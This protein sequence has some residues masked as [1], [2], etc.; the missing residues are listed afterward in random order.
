MVR[1]RKTA[2]C[3]FHEALGR[4]RATA[5]PLPGPSAGPQEGDQAPLPLAAERFLNRN[6]SREPTGREA[7]PCDTPALFATTGGLC[8]ASRPLSDG[9]SS[10]GRESR[11]HSSRHAG[12]AAGADTAH[13]YTQWAFAEGKPPVLSLSK[14]WFPFRG[15][16]FPQAVCFQQRAPRD[17]LLQHDFLRW[18]T[19]KS[20]CDGDWQ[21]CHSPRPH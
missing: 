2:R 1:G 16:S 3:S 9:V 15:P 14:G 6:D 7:P 5:G 19:T 8:G 4:N 12:T 18:L 20:T 21:L 11:S 13:C 10:G 17:P